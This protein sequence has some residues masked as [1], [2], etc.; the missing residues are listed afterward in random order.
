MEAAPPGS[1]T[2]RIQPSGPLRG[3]VR[4]R[5][6]KNAI[7]K[8]LVAA[9]MGARPSTIH[10]APDVGDVDITAEILESLGVG[11]ERDGS[12]ITV[13]PT[14][15]PQALVRSSSAA[16]TASRSCWPARC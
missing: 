6:S 3:D 10:N 11:V 2:W 8:H 5:G 15:S 9:M 4:V 14:A 1:G 12:S 16:A 13:H 7:T